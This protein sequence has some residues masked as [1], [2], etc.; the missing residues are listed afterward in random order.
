MDY[1][2]QEFRYRVSNWIVGTSTDDVEHKQ[3]IN[4]KHQHS[5]GFS[6]VSANYEDKQSKNGK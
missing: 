5:L 2:Q 1:S 3:E 6:N 4:Y